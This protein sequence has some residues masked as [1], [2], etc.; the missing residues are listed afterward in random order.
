MIE[1]IFCVKRNNKEI[2]L[3][4]N[5]LGDNIL[6]YI[7][8]IHNSVTQTPLLLSQ[9]ALRESELKAFNS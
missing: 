6:P 4:V 3:L 2:S 7:H 8:E 9:K 5:L 1:K